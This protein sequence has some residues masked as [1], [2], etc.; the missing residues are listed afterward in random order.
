M[1]SNLI[2]LSIIGLIIVFWF[3]VILKYTLLRILKLKLSA[4]INERGQT[5]D[6]KVIA[7]ETKGSGKFKRQKITVE[8]LNFAQTPITEEFRFVDTKPEQYRYE[9]GKRVSLILNPDLKKGGPIKLA[10]ASTQISKVFILISLLII[11]GYAYGVFK[12]YEYCTAI[13]GGNWANYEMLVENN[14]A[15]PTVGI[16]FLSVLIFNS[17]IFKMI[18]SI[19]KSKKNISDVE[20]KYHGAKAMAAINKYEDTGVSVNDNPMVKFHYTFEDK[21]GK[22]HVSD[23]KIIV[24][25]LDIGQLPALKEKEVLYLVNDPSQSKFV[26]NLKPNVLGGC[27]KGV[28]Y[29]VAFI[30]S[31]ILMVMFIV[32]LQN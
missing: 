6:G 2:S 15:M 25:K 1:N 16:V 9:V 7:S 4:N 22:V 5:I 30:F 8:F 14:E 13:L 23:D 18:S 11:S 28:S 20:L 19:T 32:S 29:L 12:L 26:E 3:I 17:F 24:G 27:L 21:Y 10:G 31:I